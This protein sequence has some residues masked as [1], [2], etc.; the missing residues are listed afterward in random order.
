MHSSKNKQKSE[1]FSLKVSLFGGA[2]FVLLELTMAIYTSS[3]AVLLDSI[4]D[5]VELVMILFSLCL[6]PL[7]YKSS[8]EK[9]PF[10]YL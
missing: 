1:Q 6:V 10:G 5:G 7:L 2:V 8:N 3:Q 9:R 4:Y